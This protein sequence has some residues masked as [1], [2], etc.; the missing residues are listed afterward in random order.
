MARNSST[1]WFSALAVL[2]VFV[3]LAWL[4]GAVL[5]LS[6]GE[7]VG[8]RVGLLA[9]GIIAA[10]ALLWY[11]RPQDEPLMATPG[12]ERDDALMAI[13]AARGRLARGVFDAK[14]MVLVTGT[15]GSCKTTIVSHAGLNPELLAGD[16]PVAAADAASPTA[17]AN[18]W[19]AGDALLVEPGGAVFADAGRWRQFVRELR[20]PRLAAAIGRGTTAARSVVVCVSCDTFFAAGAGVELE[21][22]AKI[23]RERLADAARELGVALPVYVVFTKADRIP[24]FES[25]VAPFTHDEITAPLGAALPFDAAAGAAGS[26]DTRISARIET[27]FAMIVASLATRRLE[28]LGRTSGMA[29]RLAAYELPRSLGKLAPA[30]TRYLSEICRPTQ[31]GVSPQLRGFY[32]VGARPIAVDHAPAAAMPASQAAAAPVVAGATSVFSRGGAASV[33]PPVAS[34]SSTGTRRVPQ[35]VFLTRLFPEVVLGD[36]GATTMATGGMRVAR[37]RRA[38]LAAGIAALLIVSFG[39]LRSWLGNRAYAERTNVAARDVAALPVVSAPAGSIALPSADALRRLDA[40]R[41][42]LDTLRGYETAGVPTRLRWGLWR[43]DDLLASGRQVWLAGYR[44]QLHDAAWTALVDSLRALPPLPRPTDDYGRDYAMLKAYLIGTTESK[45][46]TPEF[47]A[48]VLLTSF[49]RGQALDAD[50]TALA[51]RQFEFYAVGLAHENPFPQTADAAVVGRGRDFLGRF[52]GA[53]Q[54]YQFMLAEAAKTTPPARLATLAPQAAGVIAATDV[55]GGF[56]AGGWRFMQNAF[57]HADRFFEGESW[58]VGDAGNARAKDRDAILAELRTRY[59]GDYVRAWQGY[60]RSLA[61]ARGGSMRDAATKLGMLGG[62]QS[63]LFAA[64]SLASRNTDT[65]SSVIAA[66]QPVKVVTSPKTDSYVFEGNQPY[67]NGLLAVQGALEQTASMPPAVDTPSTQ[68]LTQSAQQSLAAVTQAKVA[69]RQLTQ[70]FVVG[71][72]GAQIGAPLAALLLAP[73][74]NA[75]QVLR[76]AASTRPPAHRVVAAGGG[77]GA[78]A[79]SAGGAAAPAVNVAALTKVLNERGG[80]LCSAMTPMLAKFPFSPDASTEASIGE[81]SAMLAPGTGALWAFQQER[82]E[83]LLVKQGNTWVA[84]PSAPVPLSAPFVAFFNRAAQV[85]NAL[86]SGGSEPRVVFTAHAVVDEDPRW[87]TLSQGNQ[88]ARFEKN[89]PPAQFVWPSASGREVKLTGQ[90]GRRERSIA[91]TNGDWAMFRFVAQ[92]AKVEGDAGM[93]AEWTQQDKNARPVAVDFVFAS[94]APVFKRGW[95]GG[96]ACAPQVTR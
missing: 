48:P 4:L 33:A 95:L 39:V 72:E 83:G 21:A 80:V 94:G 96:M 75:D 36:R 82:L 2:I 54:I 64:L 3:L 90:Y 74:E 59:R 71:G 31:L 23:T 34:L 30:V 22:L 35:W 43:G 44:R 52:A 51:R 79:P 5:S 67:L 61:I 86:F 8:L 40:L 57:A 73:L 63:P 53:E 27:A 19:V 60:I 56:T 62:G 15:T 58:V 38:M 24:D 85:S 55:P 91:Q 69:A 70:K 1:R 11:L 78:K 12:A 87:V 7:R 9:L 10:A 89:T 20:A 84:S 77:G 28:L 32:F 49:A 66:F 65:D 47:M 68:A 13:A 18:L 6:E 42:V 92:A 45:R 26:Y 41:S 14:Q 81:V 17:A 88:S 16:A 50:V 76:G 93:H 29:P 25:W 37:L 46:S